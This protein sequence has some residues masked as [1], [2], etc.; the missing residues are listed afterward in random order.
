MS[1]APL[2]NI[3]IA[4]VGSIGAPILA[5]LLAEPSF[6]V[7]ILTRETSRAQFPANIPVREVSDTFTVEELTAAFKGQD[8]VVVAISTTPVAKDDLA[9][10]L[11]DAAVAAGVRRFVPSEFAANNLDP[12]ARK[13]VPV[14]DAKGRMLEYL[15]RKAGE[16]EGRLTWTSFSCGSWLDWALNPSKSGNFLG[17]DIK[18][19][20]AAIWDSGRSTFSTTTSRTTG[21]AVARALSPAHFQSTANRQIFLSDFV[22][23]PRDIVEALEKE[24]GEKFAIEQK[25]SRSEVERLRE[26]FEG[27][28]FNATYPLIALSF[29]ADVDVE[30]NFA[31]KYGEDAMWNDKLGVKKVTLEEVVKEAVELSRQS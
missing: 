23:S 8:A 4:G 2:K 13:L 25:E 29:V 3:I 15:I 7:T 9:F 16:S 31:A 22:S 26:R 27:G 28:D 1:A 30:L 12:L 18:A 21:E 20:R 5:A 6:T 14:Y 17:I 24:I 19:R 11:I 10:K